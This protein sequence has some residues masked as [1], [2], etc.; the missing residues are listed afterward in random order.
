MIKHH[1]QNNLGRKGLLQLTTLRLHSINE[2]SQG[3]NL[4]VGTGIGLVAFF[5]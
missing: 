2:G 3:R 4:E 1:D 5:S